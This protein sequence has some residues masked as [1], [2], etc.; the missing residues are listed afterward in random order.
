MSVQQSQRVETAAIPDSA[1][2]TDPADV[3]EARFKAWRN[4]VDDLESY[5]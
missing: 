5:L 3:L 1:H 4:L 2:A